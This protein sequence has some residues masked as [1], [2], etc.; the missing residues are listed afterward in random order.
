VLTDDVRGNR[1]KKVKYLK[2]MDIVKINTS[3]PNF[4]TH[5]TN[6]IIWNMLEYDNDFFTSANLLR[7][8]QMKDNF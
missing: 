7:Q 8:K 1:A 2:I 4:K 6:W 3:E 5:P